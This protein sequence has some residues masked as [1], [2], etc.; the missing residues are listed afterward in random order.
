MAGPAN[1]V[2]TQFSS[3]G[4]SNCHIDIGSLRFTELPD[5]AKLPEVQDVG[6]FTSDVNLKR[7]PCT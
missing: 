6:Q 2:P 1:R 4:L 3:P 7:F 5:F